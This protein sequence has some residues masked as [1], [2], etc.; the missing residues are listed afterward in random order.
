MFSLDKTRA[1]MEEK[2]IRF[3]ESTGCSCIGE[4]RKLTADELR[5]AND[6]L[7]G[8]GA[9]FNIYTDGYVLPESIEDCIKGGRIR[10]VEIITGCTADEGANDKPPMFGSPMPAAIQRFAEVQRKNGKKP[11]Y[12]YV[13]DREQPG[14]D[15]GVPHSCDNRYQFGSLDGSWRPYEECDRQ[16][17]EKM[18]RYWANFAKTGDP[19]RDGTDEDPGLPVWTPADGTGRM[20]RLSV[21]DMGMREY[22]TEAL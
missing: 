2:G 11:V 9:G 8:L 3:M 21:E 22:R 4:M 18:Q 17:S 15:V 20:M 5:I 19:N 12:M 10:D 16:L 13:F 1:E 6:K 14:D 7:G